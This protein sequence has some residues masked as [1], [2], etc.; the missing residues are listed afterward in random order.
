[1]RKGAFQFIRTVLTT[2]ILQQFLSV[3]LPPLRPSYFSPRTP[4]GEPEG[5]RFLKDGS[6]E[7]YPLKI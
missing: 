7:L 3:V 6:K 2:P 4:Q 1:M 5:A